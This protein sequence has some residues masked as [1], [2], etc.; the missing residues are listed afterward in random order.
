R[1]PEA[2]NLLTT[3]RTQQAQALLAD[4]ARAAWVPTLNYQLGLA[5]KDSGKF[6]EARAAFEQLS[7]TFPNSPEALEAS[8]RVGQSQREEAVTKLDAAHKAMTAAGADAAK[9]ASAQGLLAAGSNAIKDAA[10]YLTAKA[11]KA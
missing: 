9:I 3:V 8:W 1:S 7:K 5:L 10:T 6:A 4:P 2:V 11:A